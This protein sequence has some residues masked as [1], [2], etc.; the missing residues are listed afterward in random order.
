MVLTYMTDPAACRKWLDM[1]ERLGLMGLVSVPRPFV[2][3]F[4]EAKLREALAV[5]K[6]HPALLGWYLFD[7][8]SPSEPN[9]RPAD[10]KRVY[11]VI[12]AEDPYH[13][14]AVCICEASHERMYL[15]CYD[16]LMIDVYPVTHNPAPLTSV[17][18][19]MDHA[20]AAVAGR[21]P[22]WNI[23]QTFGWDVIAGIDRQAWVTPTPAQTRVM[24]YLAVTHNAKALVAYCY[25]VYTRYDAEAAKAGKWAYV[26]G[27]HLPDQQAKLWGELAKLGPEL[28]ALA[29]A[30]AQPRQ[31]TRVLQDGKVHVG[32][33]YGAGQAWVVA[34][35]AD[36][37]QTCNVDLPLPAGLGK[38]RQARD[39][40]LGG[41]V[42]LARSRLRLSLPPQT[43][44]AAQLTF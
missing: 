41:K 30:L 37:K 44:A 25:H 34:T 14:V 9:Q 18:D 13:P 43:A 1:C 17:A 31:E 28:K 35:N 23:P 5:V 38:P 33:F 24:Y 21:K 39:L 8:P 6:D 40:A 19:R 22:V 20:W 42:E 2:D 10:L 27:G 32:W 16:V 4:D 7:E 36:D 15:D 26:L 3:T 11:D 12:A 29:P